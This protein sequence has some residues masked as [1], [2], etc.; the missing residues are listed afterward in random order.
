MRAVAVI[1]DVILGAMLGV[2]LYA[3]AARIWP[4]LQGRAALAA[5]LAGAVIVVLFRRPNG[6]LARPRRG[7]ESN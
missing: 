1:T 6:S 5:I 3:A 7:R 4:V 2:F